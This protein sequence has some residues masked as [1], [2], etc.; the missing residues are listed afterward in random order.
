MGHFCRLSIPSQPQCACSPHPSM[1]SHSPLPWA[2]WRKGKKQNK[3][4]KDLAKSQPQCCLMPNYSENRLRS[5]SLFFLKN[6]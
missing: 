1:P 6:A 4:N 3:Q 2:D 5:D